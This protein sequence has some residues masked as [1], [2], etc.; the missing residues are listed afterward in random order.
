MERK[1]EVCEAELVE[2]LA[3]VYT[4]ERSNGEG[5][6]SLDEKTFVQVDECLHAAL[7]A[8]R[9]SSADGHAWRAVEWTRTLG[10]YIH[11]C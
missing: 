6:A 7:E 3:K 1:A 2:T 9:V 4:L 5:P 11:A 10:M 8:A